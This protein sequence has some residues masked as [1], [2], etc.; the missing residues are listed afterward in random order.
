MLGFLE[1]SYDFAIVV[2]RRN[3]RRPKI[4]PIPDVIIS[5]DLKGHDNDFGRIRNSDAMRRFFNCMKDK[6]YLRR[7]W[8]F[9]ANRMYGKF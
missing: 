8:K 4:I 6:E 2:F 1:K 5:E 9:M 3:E 7:I